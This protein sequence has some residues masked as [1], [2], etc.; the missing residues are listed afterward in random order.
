MSPKILKKSAS[1][2]KASGGCSTNAGKRV[3]VKWGCQKVPDPMARLRARVAYMVPSMNIPSESH[4]GEI[5]SRNIPASAMK[6]NV[7]EA[8]GLSIFIV[9][10]IKVFRR[11]L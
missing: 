1:I 6:K 8:A 7:C 4:V 5:I 11:N 2:P 10:A 3:F 9:K